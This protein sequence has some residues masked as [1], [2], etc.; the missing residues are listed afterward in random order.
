MAV[1]PS[2]VYRDRLAQE[3]GLPPRDIIAETWIRANILKNLADRG[4]HTI[5]EVATFC[6]YYTT[7]PEEAMQKI[8]LD[9]QRMLK[10]ISARG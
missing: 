10:E 9:R 5:K 8:G 6:R 3:S 2:T 4:V 1:S 7:H